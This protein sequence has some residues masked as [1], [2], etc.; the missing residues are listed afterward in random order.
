MIDST[1]THSALVH[2]A[3]VVSANV[4]AWTVALTNLNSLLTTISILLATSYT[5]YKFVK[6]IKSNKKS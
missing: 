4:A 5:I 3:K 6:E 1:H 2:I